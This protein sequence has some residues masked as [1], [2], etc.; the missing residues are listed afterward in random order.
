NGEKAA[1][2]SLLRRGAELII[3]NTDPY[4]LAVVKYRQKKY[5]EALELVRI[6]LRS[7]PQETHWAYLAWGSILEDQGMLEQALEKFEKSARARP[8]FPLAYVR[9]ALAFNRLDRQAEGLE[10]MR[11]ALALD[12]DNLDRW[13]G[14]AWELHRAGRYEQADSAFEKMTL[15]APHD[16]NV[17]ST[18]ADSK[19]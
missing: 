8:D 3:T 11:K 7:R 10:A 17:W 18:W 2:D 1:L 5:E 14:F 4:R 6:M 13:Q 15:L 19:V 12:P 9:Q 16:P